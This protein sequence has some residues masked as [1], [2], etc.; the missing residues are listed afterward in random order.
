LDNNYYLKRNDIK[1]PK[2][3]H[4]FSFALAQNG[5]LGEKL[6]TMTWEIDHREEDSL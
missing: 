2:E 4:V 6:L 5:S 1:S 3:E